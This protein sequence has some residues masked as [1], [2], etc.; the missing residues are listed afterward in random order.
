MGGLNTWRDP[1][2]PNRDKHRLPIEE[3]LK[4]NGDRTIPRVVVTLV[5]GSSSQP[6]LFIALCLPGT[7]RVKWPLTRCFRP[8]AL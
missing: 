7:T 5:V 1:T 8:V 2:A 4:S 3:I 6:L